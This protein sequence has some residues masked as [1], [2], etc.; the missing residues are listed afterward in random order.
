MSRRFEPSRRELARMLLAL[1]AAPALARVDEPSPA[2]PLAEFLA[3]NEP[4]LSPAERAALRRSVS[5][6]EKTLQLIRD[7]ELPPDAAPCLRFAA[8]KSGGR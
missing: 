5:G 1:P 3:A 8:L 7:F 2:S 6:L 4:G